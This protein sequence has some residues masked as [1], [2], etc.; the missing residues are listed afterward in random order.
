MNT[1][2]QLKGKEQDMHLIYEGSRAWNGIH[3]D[4][5]AHMELRHKGRLIWH[6]SYDPNIDWYEQGLKDA[7]QW[8]SENGWNWYW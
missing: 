5:R 7:R 4:G 2:I 8:C 3:G 1:N 6:Q